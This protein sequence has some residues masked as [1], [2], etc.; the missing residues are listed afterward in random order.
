MQ[1]HKE[2]SI[3]SYLELEGLGD[4]NAPINR[5]QNVPADEEDDEACAGKLRPS[6]TSTVWETDEVAST[7]GGAQ[8][9]V[10]QLHT[11][12]QELERDHRE[13]SIR[14]LEIRRRRE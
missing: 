1:H 2:A 12:L 5:F 3:P 10:T 4:H 14:T 7:E 13:F 9:Y 6:P 8:R 11:E